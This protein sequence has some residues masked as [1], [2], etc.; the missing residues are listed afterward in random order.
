MNVQFFFGGTTILIVVGVAMD[1]VSAGGIAAH[2]EALRRL[3][4]ED[5]DPRTAWIAVTDRRAQAQRSDGA[6]SDH[7]GLAGCRKGT[8]AERF[9]RTRGIPKISTGDILRKA[10]DAGTEV[11]HARVRSWSAVSWS[12]MM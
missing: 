8:Q 12:A 7:V 10:V 6:E 5:S 1:T 11:G 4:E 2:H 3:H 9:A